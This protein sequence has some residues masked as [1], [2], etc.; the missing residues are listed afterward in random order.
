M[1]FEFSKGVTTM[2]PPRDLTRPRNVAEEGWC[3]FYS[4][5]DERSCPYA[6]AHRREAW[7]LGHRS[8]SDW[9]DLE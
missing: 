5:R 4:G 7:M 3:A 6:D 2:I 1:V 8:A 9:F